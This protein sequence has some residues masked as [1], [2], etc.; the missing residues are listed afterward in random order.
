MSERYEYP[1]AVPCWVETFQPDVEAALDFYSGLFGW[2][3]VGPG[4]LG[5]PGGSG[6]YYV[7]RLRGLDVAGI[8]SLPSPDMGALWQTSLAVA[9]VAAAV[10]SV[11]RAGGTVLAAEIDAAPAGR[12]AVVADLFGAVHGLWQGGTRA[13][14]QLVNEPGAWAMS[15]LSVPDPDLAAD[16]YGAAYG[17]TTE[18]LG[19]GDGAVTLFRLPG[20]VGGEPEQPVSREVVATMVRG[21]GHP[22]WTPNFWAVDAAVAQQLTMERGGRTIVP[23]FT[24]PPGT[25]VVLADPQGA[26]FSVTGVGRRD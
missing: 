24:T 17:W 15:Q 20:Y 18:V 7:A 21:H 12:S 4:P 2:E 11:V 23:P 10:E 13:G 5:G 6:S 9:G 1:A 8:G 22:Q 16:F 3:P 26:L 25:T 14:A 19:S